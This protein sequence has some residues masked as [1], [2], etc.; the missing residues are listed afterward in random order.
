M[1]SAAPISELEA[2]YHRRQTGFIKRERARAYAASFQNWKTG[3]APK[4]SRAAG[5]TAP[6]MEPLPPQRLSV[7]RPCLHPPAQPAAIC[8]GS[9]RL[10]PEPERWPVQ[11]VTYIPNDPNHEGWGW[12]WLERWMVARP[13][14]NRSFIDASDLSRKV[15]P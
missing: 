15:R 14:R 11:T 10:L 1:S 5:S 3:P 2:D 8:P 7:G 9:P 13:W 4:V 6:V 12:G